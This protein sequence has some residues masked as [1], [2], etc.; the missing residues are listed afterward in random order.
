MSGAPSIV[1]EVALEDM[2]TQVHFTTSMT[3]IS[4]CY[5]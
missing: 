5:D 3:V 4:Y 2:F 1:P